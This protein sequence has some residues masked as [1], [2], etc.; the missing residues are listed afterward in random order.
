MKDSELREKLKNIC[1]MMRGLAFE[2]LNLAIILTTIGAH[3]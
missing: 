1:V 3:L 2:E